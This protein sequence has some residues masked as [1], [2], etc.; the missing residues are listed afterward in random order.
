MNMNT[1]A[2]AK[3]IQKSKPMLWPPGLKAL[4][5]SAVQQAVLG[6]V[7]ARP[8]DRDANDVQLIS[9]TAEGRGQI[10]DSENDLHGYPNPKPTARPFNPDDWNLFDMTPKRPEVL[11]AG[12]KARGT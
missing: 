9:D 2:P 4:P 12:A 5:A 7:G 11:D 6:G 10:I 3:I 8:W 1:T